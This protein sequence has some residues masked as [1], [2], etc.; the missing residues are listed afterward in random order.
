MV[1]VL[2]K[3][4]AN[5]LRRSFSAAEDNLKASLLPLL[6]INWAGIFNNVLTTSFTRRT[7]IKFNLEKLVLSLDDLQSRR[8]RN[9]LFCWEFSGRVLVG[10]D[11]IFILT[12]L[13][14]FQSAAA[15]LLFHSTRR[16]C[17]PRLIKAFN[18]QSLQKK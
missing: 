2:Q 12:F 13:S 1:C 6:L 17:S 10:S 5:D 14:V 18:G 7:P 9:F 15:C 4:S 16:G 11:F 8:D 3:K